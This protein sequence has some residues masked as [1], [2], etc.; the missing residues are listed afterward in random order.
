MLT[1]TAAVK[2]KPE[3][4]LEG[5][6]SGSV[7]ESLAKR[8]SECGFEAKKRVSGSGV[9]ENVK[10]WKDMIKKKELIVKSR[11]SVL[12]AWTLVAVLHS[13]YV[14]GG[15]ALGALL[16]PGRDLLVDGLR[17]F[18]KGSPNM[19]SLV[20]FGSVAFI[21]SVIS[22]LSPELEWDASFFE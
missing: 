5:E 19:N 16:G 11:N 17:A 4:L 21:I 6:M 22:L 2:L 9:A 10:M 1:E 8:L 15:L 7:A 18:K 14:K 20:G 13:S 3:A 12:F